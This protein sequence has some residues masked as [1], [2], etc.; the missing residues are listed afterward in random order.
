MEDWKGSADSVSKVEGG[1]QMKEVLT[2][3]RHTQMVVLVALSAAIYAAVLIPFKGFPLVPGYIE[4]R[5][6]NAFPIVFGLLFG[7]A[8]AWGAAIGNLIG[9]FFGTLSLG[10]I[11]G[12]VGNFFLA[13]LP[14][15]MWSVF[16]RRDENM[17]ENV[18]SGKKFGVFILLVLLASAVCAVI[19]AYGID[20][21]G[22]FPFVAFF[23]LIFFNNAV[24]G[25]V[26]GPILLLAL[27]P[28][29]KRWGLLWTEIVEPEDASSS[30]LK[31]TGAIL[32]WVGAIGA[33]AVGL[34]LGLGQQAPVNV[35]IGIGLIPFFLLILVGSFMLGVREQIEAVEETMAAESEESRA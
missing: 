18:D 8:G 26:L 24:M 2:M 22:F 21:L 17:E 13:L 12:F 31:R 33:V 9:D 32:V 19:I 1:T 10:S 6:A 28:R 27:Y 34:I 23:A 7:P 3:W 5:P 25:G 35:G 15:K 30:R 20:L 16:F 4:L 14:Y 29:V 11:G